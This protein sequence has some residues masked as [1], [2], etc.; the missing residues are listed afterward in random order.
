MSRAE[1]EERARERLEIALVILVALAFGASF[2][3]NYLSINQVTYLIPS[4]R[5]L[6]PELFR[7][8]WFATRTTQFHPAFALLGALLLSLDPSGWALAIPL[9]LVVAAGTSALYWM[10]RSAAGRKLALP[11]Y[12]LLVAF[13]FATQTRGPGTTYIFEHE[14]QPSALSSAATLAAAACFVAGRFVASGAFVALVGIFHVNLLVLFGPALAIAHVLLGRRTLGVRL[15]RQL[16]PAT[17]VLAAFLPMLLRDA[18]SIAGEALARHLYLDVRFAH[19]FGL[20]DHLLD[21]VPLV[22]WLAIALSLSLPLVS[23]PERVALRRLSALGFGVASIVLVGVA[24]PLLAPPPLDARIKSLFSWRLTAH[25]ELFL[26]A[27]AIASSCALTDPL[28]RRRFGRGALAVASASAVLLVQHYLW[29]G[30]RSAGQLLLATLVFV[31]AMAVAE[32]FGRRAA[33]ASRGGTPSWLRSPRAPALA[34]GAAALL[35]FGLGPLRRIREHSNLLGTTRPCDPSLYRWMR[36]HTPK[37]ALFLTPPT[38]EFVRYCGE[39]AI[40]V[41]WKCIPGIP[42]EILDWHQRLKDVT[43]K[44]RIDS[45]DDLEGYDELGAA[46]LAELK[47][48]YGITYVVVRR[49]H[50]QALSSYSR[51]FEDATFVAFDVNRP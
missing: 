30:S 5:L 16:G 7:N 22:A 47:A 10:L 18:R 45:A 37:D 15:V 26:Q 51:V 20:R 35:Y 46:R 1:P 13:A 29:R 36:E 43:G 42:A 2:G 28:L 32:R 23:D 38:D 41:D 33:G 48:R 14:F 40:V 21:F 12:L 8:D 50:E 24:G 11:S 3:W 9:T 49:G 31:L 17:L 25:A 39:R 19:H 4:R 27:C 6:D 34:F 44:N